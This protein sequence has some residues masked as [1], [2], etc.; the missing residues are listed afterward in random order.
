MRRRENNHGVCEATWRNK[1]GRLAFVLFLILCQYGRPV[2]AQF[3]G[4]SLQTAP[5]ENFP[6]KLTTDPAIL[7]PKPRDI[8]LSAGDLI[9][10][11]MYGPTDYS[12]TVRVG[13]DGSV[14]LPLLG[15]VHVGGLTVPEAQTMVADGLRSAG[16]FLN[17]Q[18]TI[19]IME[20]PTQSVTLTGE[21]HGVIPIAGQRRLYDVLAM[22]G[23]FPP[24]A[25]HTITIDRPGVAEQIVIDLGTDPAKS[26]MGNVPIFAHDTIITGRTGVIYLLGAFKVQGPVQ[27]VQST[28]LTLMQATAIGGGAPFTGRLK[29]LRVIRTVGQERQVVTLDL[30]RVLNGEVPDPVLQPDDIVFLPTDKMKAAIQGG[31][32]A[33]LL[34]LASILLFAFR[35]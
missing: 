20:S 32:V 3:N 23:G 11:H 8:R 19:Q 6:I 14:Q 28:P 2:Q 16:M 15:I 7:Y 29:D 18:I 21:V 4:P 9:A 24:T 30:K 31:G 26:A 5:T 10:F 25:S 17:P 1:G 22:A 27:L 34:A 33:S 12:P 35:D 13:E